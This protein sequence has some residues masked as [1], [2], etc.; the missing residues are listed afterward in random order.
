[1][2]EN[3]Q[4]QQTLHKPRFSIL[5]PTWNNLEYLKFC[6]NSLR[7]NSRFT[8]QIIVFVNEGKDGTA[9]W[10]AEQKD[11]DF[12]HDQQNKGVCYA[13]NACRTLVK[14]DY[15]VYMNDDMYD[16]PDLDF[17]L[18]YEIK[19][20][21]TDSFYISAT[22]IEPV[23]LNNPN[24]VAIIR[25]FGDSPETFNE[26]G[27]LSELPKLQTENWRGSSWPPSVVHKKIWDLVGGFSIEF[28]PGMYSDP[29]FS[30]KLWQA[31]VRIFMGVG[32]SKVYH[33]GAKSTKR[34]RKNK[35]SDTFLRKWGITANTFYSKILGLGKKYEGPYPE[36]IEI[37][38][39][40]KLR[41][42]LK[43]IAKS[44]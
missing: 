2:N 13:V 21:E 29:D 1:M 5:I 32:K 43:R 26:E 6:I 38:G 15:M 40:S 28:T 17:E 23:K 44:F 9:E 11:I 10:L 8:N 20:L 35:G 14:A 3:N 30:M 39:L 25:D 22:L 42:K 41:N 37:D 24:Y 33:F 31:G 7:K 12:I 18:M 36:S 34:V 27:L 16:G 4:H 19:Q